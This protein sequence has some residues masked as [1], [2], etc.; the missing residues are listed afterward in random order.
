MDSDENIWSAVKVIA[1]CWQSQ[2]AK[3]AA[4]SETT[5]SFEEWL[6]WEAFYACQ[7]AGLDPE[8]KTNYND[9]GA[10]GFQRQADLRL[11]LSNLQEIVI[12][13]GLIHDGTLKPKWREKLKQDREK[14]AHIR[15][16]K[17]ARLQIVISTCTNPANIAF[18]NSALKELHGP[19]A[20]PRSYWLD[21][22]RNVNRVIAWKT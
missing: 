21:S 3:I 13:I 19:S 17:I 14:L 15:A 5:N 18:W 11:R 22:A 16:G 2:S 9:L 12:E 6:N 10:V 7:Q 4:F 20:Q 8:A 1:E